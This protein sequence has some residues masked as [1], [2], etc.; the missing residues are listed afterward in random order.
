MQRAQRLC[1]HLQTIHSTTASSQTLGTQPTAATATTTV[2]TLASTFKTDSTIIQ[3][4]Q[5]LD[6]DQ[7][8][9]QKPSASSSPTTASSNTLNTCT[10]AEWQSK[11][12]SVLGSSSFYGLSQHHV[13]TFSVL[14]GD[15]QWIHQSDAAEN[16]SPFRVPIAHGFLILSMISKIVTEVVPHIEGSKYTISYGL[17]KVS[18]SNTTQTETEQ[19]YLSSQSIS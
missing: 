3:Q 10:L 13:D 2:Q 8:E 9:T 7:R 5:L 12:Q 19:Q 11:Q 17:N 14:T 4:L 18:N 16:G 15:Y 6:K 1:Q